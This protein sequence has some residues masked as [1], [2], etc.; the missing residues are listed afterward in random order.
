VLVLNK[1][2]PGIRGDVQIEVTFEI[3]INGIVN[4]AAVDLDTGQKQAV[5][6]NL[7]GSHNVDES[8]MMSNDATAPRVR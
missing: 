3:D 7:V 8:D 6:L 5:R 2:R 1:L 4:V